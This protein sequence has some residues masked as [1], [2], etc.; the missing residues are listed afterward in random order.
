MFKNI[1]KNYNLHTNLT[2]GNNNM[3][4]RNKVIVKKCTSDDILYYKQ[5]ANKPFATKPQLKKRKRNH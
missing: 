2:K 5:L 3:N 4:M 1:V